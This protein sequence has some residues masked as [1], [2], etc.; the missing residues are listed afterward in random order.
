MRY[1][2]GWLRRDR[3]SMAVEFVVAVPAIVLLLLLVSAGGQW[4]DLT[5]D[6]GSA[7]RDAVR[8]A[9]LARDFT[10]A[11]ARAQNAARADLGGV[12]GGGPAVKVQLFSGGGVVGPAGFP[13][14]RDIEVTVTC[15]GSLEAFHAVGF[16]V[17]QTFGDTA[18]APLDP[19]ED[20]GT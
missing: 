13:A 8:A 19:F 18:A 3:G 5:G 1:L 4:L 11:Q 14:A 15:L 16:P 7:A 20:R 10:D 6:V 2:K 9:S 12:C 17:R